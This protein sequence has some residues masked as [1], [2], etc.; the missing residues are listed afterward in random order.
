MRDYGS[1]VA[2]VKRN[3]TRATYVWDRLSQAENLWRNQIK[4]KVLNST[5]EKAKVSLLKFLETG[6]RG[7]VRLPKIV[8]EYIDLENMV[9]SMDLGKI[10]DKGSWLK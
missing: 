2:A 10:N 7:K 9:I 1:F 5:D 8:K 4:Q 6:R 3:H